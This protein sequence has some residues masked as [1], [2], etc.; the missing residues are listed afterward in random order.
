MRK[1]ALSIHKPEHREIEI[2]P[3]LFWDRF[4]IPR[5]TEA[6]TPQDK[7][8]PDYVI[9]DSN[10]TREMVVAHQDG[11]TVSV[12]ASHNGDDANTTNL[13]WQVLEQVVFM[14]VAP[15]KYKGRKDIGFISYIV[16]DIHVSCDVGT[17]VILPGN[18]GKM[19]RGN[20]ESVTMHVISNVG[21]KH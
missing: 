9:H 1:S 16:S 15:V 20:K 13:I 7:V 11:F 3:K 8:W 21:I 4:V 19:S 10:L 17:S 14:K 6:A 18:D 5:L 2:N 12:G